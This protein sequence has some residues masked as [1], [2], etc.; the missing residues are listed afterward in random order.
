MPDA[1]RSQPRKLLDEVRNVLRLHHYS[2]HTERSYVEWI[3]RFVRVHG[4]RSRDHLFPAEPQIE[5][6]L[7]DLA[8]H[9]HMAPTAQLQAMPALVCLDTHVPNHA[10]KPRRP[11]RRQEAHHLVVM[12]R[13]A[14]A[15][16]LSRMNGPTNWWSYCSRHEIP[17]KIAADGGFIEGE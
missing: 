3:I 17:G 1:T 7:T 13:E 10:M 16:V 14:V 8:V 11:A 5:A 15:A 2:I 12:T 4:R 6:F 9:G